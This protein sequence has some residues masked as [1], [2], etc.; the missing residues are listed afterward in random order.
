MEEKYEILTEET[1]HNAIN[2]K[3]YGF[4]WG[5]RYAHGTD[6]SDVYKIAFCDKKY[7]VTQQQK[8]KATRIMEKVELEKKH[9]YLKSNT[10]VFNG[11]GMSFKAKP[12]YIG[13]HR[14][15]ASFIN[16][17][18]IKCFIEV[19]TGK[20][21]DL[22]RCNH[23]MYNYVNVCNS[24]KE[25]DLRE[26]NNYGNIERSLSLKYTFDNLL[27]LVNETFNCNYKSIVLEEHFL[28]TDV[29]TSVCEEE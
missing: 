9:Q 11:M 4:L 6:Q 25:R 5:V 23:S 27:K 19:G 8:Q 15:R 3:D 10:L 29:F 13:N 12:G 28:R 7:Y 22:M 26:K 2:N 1:F 20:E 14:I 16:L 24:L 18:G 17:D 21:N